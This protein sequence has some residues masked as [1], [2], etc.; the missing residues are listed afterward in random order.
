[1][2][3]TGWWFGTWMD[4]D[5]PLIL[6]MSSS[7]LTNSIIFQRGRAQAPSSFYGCFMGFTGIF[8][9][10][11]PCEKPRGLNIIHHDF[12]VKSGWCYIVIY[13][14]YHSQ[15]HLLIMFENTIDTVIFPLLSF[16]FYIRK[17]RD[18]S[19]FWIMLCHVFAIKTGDWT[20]KWDDYY[21]C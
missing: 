3:Y 2:R 13:S 7:Q 5:F 20:I 18:S 4:Y 17:Y 12:M 8:M 15:K 6:G 9:G 11:W 10:V 1:M 19:Q 14:L 21:F 16:P